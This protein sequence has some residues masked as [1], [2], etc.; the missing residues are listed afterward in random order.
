MPHPIQRR[1]VSEQVLDELKRMIK[2]GQFP[3]NSKL[4]S[5]TELAKMFK[6]S[7]APVREALS[8]LAA[9][10]LI[11]SKQ[12]GG[13]WVKDVQLND[14]LAATTLEMVSNEQVLYL[15]ETRMILETEAAA[16]AAQRFQETDL[17]ALKQAQ[18]EF[19]RIVEEEESIGDRA[20]V[21][22]HLAVVRASH[23]PIL[24]QMVENIADL[25][26]KVLR[27]TLKQNVGWQRKREQVFAE[28]EAIVSAIRQRDGQ[29]A[30]QKM[31]EHLAHVQEKLAGDASP[32]LN[33]CLDD[34]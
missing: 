13:S 23:N 30:R 8:V 2:E 1:K 15:L 10:G 31:A 28:H 16:L 24:I 11:E 9:S 18:N 19:Q 12:G 25:Y 26:H 22:F 14:M 7:R 17:E 33:R 27:F 5:E 3:P 32:F 29:L 4:P 20:D 6:V 34:K 21:D